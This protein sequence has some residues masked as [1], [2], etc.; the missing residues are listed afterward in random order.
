M[1]LLHPCKL[2]KA[3]S[4]NQISRWQAFQTFHQ[5]VNR[6]DLAYLPS[7]AQLVSQ[8]MGFIRMPLCPLPRRDFHLFHH[9]QWPVLDS[10]VTF[11]QALRP[12]TTF[13]TFTT[14]KFLSVFPIAT[15]NTHHYHY[16]PRSFCTTS[17]TLHNGITWILL[18]AHHLHHWRKRHYQSTH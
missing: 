7:M 5:L 1:G 17:N 9:A 3:S 15:I 8:K 16:F 6:T 18:S 10:K 2:R 4:T 13:T 14:S 11:A 12:F